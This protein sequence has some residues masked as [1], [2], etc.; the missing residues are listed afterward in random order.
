MSILNILEEGDRRAP[1]AIAL[2]APGRS[3]IT[4]SALHAH[5]VRTAPALRQRG[6]Q[7]DDI[8]AIVL[9]NGPETASPFLSLSAAGLCAPLN[10]A[11]QADELEFYLSDLPARALIVAGLPE[12]PAREVAR[13]LGIQVIE[14]AW[15]P[16]DSAGMFALDGSPAAE[17]DDSL[18][19]PQPD[20]VALVLHTSGTTSRPKIVPLTHANLVA[21]ARHIATS[22]MLTPD[23]LSL[24]VMPLFHIHGLVASLLASLHGGGGVVCT[25]G[26]VAPSFFD[27]MGEFR[28]TWY[29]AVPTMHASIVSRAAASEAGADSHT[30]RFIRSS[31]AALPRT[32]LAKLEEVFRVAVIEAY[33]MTE[34]AHQMAS[35]PL[36]PAV[37]KP[38]TVGRA[39]G[40]AIAVLGPDG[41]PVSP[42]VRGEI[43]I[44][45]P[46]ITPGYVRNP[47]ANAAAFID[48]WLRTGDEG[49]LDDDGYLTILGRLK[50]IINR[51]GEKV[52]PLEVDE[53][54]LAHPAVA[55][56]VTFGA[57]DAVLGEEVAAAIVL[58]E[59]MTVSERALREFVAARLALFKVP[60][61]VLFM[62]FIP[63]GP[64]GK[65]QRIGLAERLGVAFEAPPASASTYVAPGT[66]VEEILAS[67]W[68]S[69]MGTAHPGV[70]EDFFYSGGDSILAA[71][72]VGRVRDALAVDISLLAFFDSPT[73]RGLASIVEAAI[74]KEPAPEHSASFR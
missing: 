59:G 50:E 3:P 24:N 38:G 72:F 40:P 73:V 69:V 70:E 17:R 44:K 31:S 7:R 68:S 74:A 1:N 37:R 19:A 33:G 20:D 34:A 67:V 11:Y 28:P 25:P 30:L 55:Q 53:V 60:R 54:L 41:H 18:E 5:V 65:P 62:S 71:Q 14:L 48:G 29:T 45:G 2:Y 46:N 4:Y 51:G 43:A 8:I 27:W 66:P 23:D 26:F 63:T 47:E 49:V 42:G 10:P 35:N 16:E 52:S 22:L 36:P 61:R 15:S 13:R 32:T 6:L 58:H 64:T 56:A 9:P 21:S 39:A 12:S 57:S